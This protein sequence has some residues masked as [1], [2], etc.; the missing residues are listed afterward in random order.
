MASN[1]SHCSKCGVTLLRAM[2]LAIAVDLGVK[3]CPGPLSCPKGGEH[4][5]VFPPKEV[6]DGST[7]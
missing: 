6:P 5:F 3:A 1:E 4:E 7:D 2:A